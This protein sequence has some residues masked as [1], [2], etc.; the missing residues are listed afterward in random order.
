MSANFE[1]MKQQFLLV[2]IVKLRTKKILKY[3]FQQSRSFVCLLPET[4]SN[5][6]WQLSNAGIKNIWTFLK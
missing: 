6:G 3:L 1:I 2:N 5:V 4:N